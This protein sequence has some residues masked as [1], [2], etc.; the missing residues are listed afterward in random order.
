MASFAKMGVWPVG[1]FRSYSS[2]LL[3]N[4][5]EV[6]ARIATINAE[7]IRIGMVTVS[8]QTEKDA[9][10][11]I[12]ATEDRAGFTVTKNSSLERL[13]RAYVAQG[14]NPTDISPFLH[15]DATE[16]I[17]EKEDGTFIVSEKDPYG[18]IIAPRSV[19]TN[20]PVP[21]QGE[22]TGY[23]Q[24]SG[25]MPRHSGYAPARQ[26]GRIDR[27]AY[28]SN[29][30]VRYMHQMRAWA[31]QTIKERVQDIEW[32]IIKLCDLREQLER[33]RDDVLM[34]AFGGA[35]IG[36]STFDEDRFTPSFRVQS[37][38]Q[39]M[40]E[41]LYEKDADGFV[42]NFKAR[43]DLSFLRFTFEDTGSETM[44]DSKG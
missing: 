36:L 31:N 41:V 42:S 40:Y 1:Y 37:M 34:Q 6:A 9:E 33:E 7:V 5:R 26:G 29:T 22:R 35:L 12:R 32:R 4:R 16:V 10:G 3:R 18:G 30:I 15:P 38:V 19:D 17:E 43:Q 24:G 28:D 27:G 44:R 23:E 14:G 8:Y 39:D 11:N 13:I 25:G 20:D 2:W 21:K